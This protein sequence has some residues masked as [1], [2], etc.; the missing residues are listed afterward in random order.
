MV[1]NIND[2]LWNTQV[3]RVNTAVNYAA[4]SFMAFADTS[5]NSE[6]SDTQKKMP[7]DR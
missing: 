5:Y 2:T 4:D 7:Y 1:N 6:M 3:E